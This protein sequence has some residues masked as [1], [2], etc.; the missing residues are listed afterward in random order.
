MLKMAFYT[1]QFRHIYIQKKRIYCQKYHYSNMDFG[2]YRRALIT[3]KGFEL[4]EA[5]YSF[6]LAPA[7]TGTHSQSTQISKCC[8]AQCTAAV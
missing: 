3:S 7:E 8:A 2:P 4:L 5:K 6:C 1:V